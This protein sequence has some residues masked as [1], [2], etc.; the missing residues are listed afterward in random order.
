MVRGDPLQ[1]VPDVV[2]A[3]GEL[4]RRG[5]AVRDVDDGGAVE[6]ADRAGDGVQLPVVSYGP[7]G[8]E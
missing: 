2:R 4:V 6:P 8:N 1:V 5:Q 3:G 7:A